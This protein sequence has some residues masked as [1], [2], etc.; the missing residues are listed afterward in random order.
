[1]CEIHPFFHSFKDPEDVVGVSGPQRAGAEAD[2][3]K[4]TV[5]GTQEVVK[6]LPLTHDPG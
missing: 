2:P 5:D 3:V 6:V 1:M 4:F